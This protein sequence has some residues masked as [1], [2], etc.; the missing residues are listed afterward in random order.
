MTHLTA[1]SNSNCVS[2]LPFVYKDQV[3]QTEAGGVRPGLRCLSESIRG[4]AA[5]QFEDVTECDGQPEATE[6]RRKGE[7]PFL[8]EGQIQQW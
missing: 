1:V 7:T 5:M 4:T 8:A 6:G 2:T 3:S